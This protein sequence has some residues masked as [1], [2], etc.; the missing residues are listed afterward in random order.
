MTPQAGALPVT[1][2]DDATPAAPADDQMA[3]AAGTAT[4]EAQATSP[5]PVLPHDLSPLGMFMAA[6]I[7][8]KA[9]MTALALASVATWAILFANPSSLPPP[10]AAPSVR[11]A[12]CRTPLFFATPARC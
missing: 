10:S 8:V 2:A 5:N 9:V 11:C 6:D 3:P 1:P 12:S 4:D 7:I